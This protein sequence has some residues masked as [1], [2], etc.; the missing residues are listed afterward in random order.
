[1]GKFEKGFRSLDET[2][3]NNVHGGR[4]GGE[5]EYQVRCIVCGWESG[6]STDKKGL[7]DAHTTATGHTGFS[8]AAERE[9]NGPSSTER[10]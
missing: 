8:D 9:K 6:W 4:S 3:L 7:M 10:V 1:M 5:M 2:E